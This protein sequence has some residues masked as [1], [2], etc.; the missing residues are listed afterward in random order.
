MRPR[1][2]PPA[3][4]AEFASAGIE[5]I[6]PHYALAIGSLKRLGQGGKAASFLL[7]M[8][9]RGLDYTKAVANAMRACSLEGSPEVALDIFEAA[10]ELHWRGNEHLDSTFVFNHALQAL[11]LQCSYDETVA[12]LLQV[13]AQP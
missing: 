9:D 5:P 8:K 4:K 6:E 10:R 1:S 11:H 13:Q 12:L 3:S 2:L 7:H